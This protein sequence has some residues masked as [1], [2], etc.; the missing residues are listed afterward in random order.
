MSESGLIRREL[1]HIKMRLRSGNW[2]WRRCRRVTSGRDSAGMDRMERI[3]RP[4]AAKVRRRALRNDGSHIGRAGREPR[5]LRTLHR[6][7]STRRWAAVRIGGGGCPLPTGGHCCSLDDERRASD[8]QGTDKACAG[9]RSTR[10]ARNDLSCQCEDGE[11][12][13]PRLLELACV[14]ATASRCVCVRS[15]NQQA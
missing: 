15:G 6:G 4:G 10:V 2:E 8:E 5:T 13:R 9:H 1:M 7:T 11:K 3:S 12:R 14:R